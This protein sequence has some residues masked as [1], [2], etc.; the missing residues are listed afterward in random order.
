MMSHE[1]RIL[2]KE[3]DSATSL[4]LSQN[5]RLGAAHTESSLAGQRNLRSQK[6]M[7]AWNGIKSLA[8]DLR[9]EYGQQAV[10]VFFLSLDSLNK[11]LFEGRL[12]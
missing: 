5:H 8:I 2:S 12:P 10:G 1:S 3:R 11:L 6:K 4:P 9:W 7:S